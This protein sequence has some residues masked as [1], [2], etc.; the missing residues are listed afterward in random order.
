[1][2]HRSLTNALFLPFMQMSSGHQHVADA[3]MNQIQNCRTKINA[4]KVDI[5]SYSYGKVERVISS[6]YL[7]WIKYFPNVYNWLYR[8]MG[9]QE[10]VAHKHNVIYEKLFTYFFRRLIEEKNP[11]ILFFTHSLPSH[12]ASRLK[13]QGMLEAV[14]VNVYTDYFVNR[15]WG[16]KGIN[17]HFVPSIIVKN[18]LIERGVKEDCIFVTGIPVD[19]IFSSSRKFIKN[20]QNLC[21][22]VSGGNHG[23]GAM[24][25]LLA[26]TCKSNQIHYFVLCGKNKS[27]YKE[28]LR[29]N[30][31]HVTPLP[32]ISCKYEMNKL[33]SY[34]DG[35]IT[36]PGGVTVSECLMKKKPLFICEPLPG[37]EK[38]NERQLN[39]LGVSIPICLQKESIDLQLYDFFSNQNK[40]LLYQ[41]NLDTFH[42]HLE[43]KPILAIIDDLLGKTLSK[44]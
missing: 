38:I 8:H 35:V 34:V 36:K 19:P 9:Y 32:Y 22:L 39:R 28:L 20:K 43:K 31:K 5:L 30:D 21:V 15:V 33:Y 4:S 14:T 40:Q 25:R 6:T 42:Q 3:L 44:I 1:M 41:Q 2:E 27:L 23:V 37:Q 12:L 18:Y 10:N 16:I 7:A 13:E 11:K 24:D 17:Y 29:M 26:K